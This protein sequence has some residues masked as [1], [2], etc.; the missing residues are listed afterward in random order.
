[1]KH[2]LPAKRK[3]KGFPL[4]IEEEG[5]SAKI[6]RT[7]SAKGYVSFVVAYSLLGRRQLQTFSDLAEAKQAAHEAC[8][9][10]AGGEQL[11]LELKNGDRMEYL[12]A[13][14][15]LA[16]ISIPLDMAAREYAD[17]IR[18]LGDRANIM[19]AVN[20]WLK[21]HDIALPIVPVSQAVTEMLE[22]ARADKKSPARLHQLR[23]Y[24]DRFSAAMNVNIGDIT[25]AHVQAYLAAMSASN[26]TKKNCRDV[27]AAFI[28]WCSAR[29]YLTRTAPLDILEHVQKY[30]GNGEGEVAIFSPEELDRLIAQAST[31]L[32]PYVAIG[33]FAG[34]R[35]AEIQR[36]DWSEI[37]LDEG[38]IEVAGAKA[39]TRMRRLVPI[40]PNLAAWLRPLAKRSGPVCP[41]K[42]VVNQLMKL[43]H[44][45]D[46]A[47]QKN[48]LRHSCISYRIA[49]C[50][51]V[52]RVADESGNSPTV[53]RTNYLKRVKPAM[54]EAWFAI[55]PA[56]EGKVVQLRAAAA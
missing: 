2:K 48:G 41:F 55:A 19:E 56:V 52:P 5:V 4:V 49:E 20:G 21:Q 24:L 18:R 44:G 10:I 15:A 11:A 36:L 26:R 39:K 9:K 33:A 46:V 3:R 1:M 43:A 8:R 47:W 17:A 40:K 51:D 32:L 34:L 35:G 7:K 45:A 25:S 42:N 22:Q 54:A 12:R 6:Y 13:K 30:G 14:E 16:P 28:K 29:G 31:R 23:T 38:F 37:D 50:A 53:I 27:L